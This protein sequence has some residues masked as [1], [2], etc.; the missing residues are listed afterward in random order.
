M[1]PPLSPAQ[2]APRD[3]SFDYL[4]ATLTLMVVA[5]HS[6]L[7]Y[8]D[9]AHRADGTVV[10]SAAPVIDAAHWRFFDY[11]ENFND[12]FFMSLMFFIS[13]LFVAPSLRRSGAKAFLLQRLLRLGLPFA[14][15][16]TTLMPLAY[17]AGWLAAGHRDGFAAYW[18]LNLTAEGWPPGPLW[19]VWLLLL[20]DILA[21]ALFATRPRLRAP[22]P[23]RPL[24]AF[25]L[26]C[27][28]AGVAYLP[29]LAIFGP[30]LWAPLLTKP[31]YFQVSRVFLYLAWFGAGVATGEGGLQKGLLARD[32]GLARHPRAWLR[33]CLVAY[34]VLVFAPRIP[35]SSELLT[36]RGVGALEAALWVLSCVTS[37]FAFVALFRALA[38][39][40][41]AWMDSLSRSAYTIY[42][43]HYVFVL[44]TQYALLGAPLPAA[45]KF[46]IV[47]TSATVLSWLTA[48]ALLRLPG[49]GRVL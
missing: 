41:R 28:L 25:T 15:A 38:R 47:I 32:G 23:D 26:M 22:V 36:A 1:E 6:M 2:S 40:R 34:N 20:F 18:R 3:V 29:M 17:Y 10:A 4:R 43:V 11:A 46:A 44:W 24:L 31:F 49:A 13:G 8:V 12:V 39:R 35:G 19:F 7:A 45:A 21:A 37:G 27:V 16:V 5:H 30:G 33:A 42:I 14:V 9:F 48:Q